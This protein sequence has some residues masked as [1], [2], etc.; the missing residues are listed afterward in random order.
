MPE[1]EEDN[2]STDVLITEQQPETDELPDGCWISDQFFSS[3][4]SPSFIFSATDQSFSPLWVLS[5]YNNNFNDG[6]DTPPENISLT[7]SGG[8]HVVLS[9][10]DEADQVTRKL[11]NN[12]MTRQLPMPILETNPPEYQ[13]ATCLIRERMTMALRYF[14]ESGYQK[15]VLAQVWAPVKKRDCYVLTTSGQPF[16]LD[17][18]CNGLHQ[19]RMASLM[20]IFSLGEPDGVLDLPARV[21]KHRLPE[22]T[23]NVQYYS[24]KE[25]QRL[26]H[27]LSYDVRGTLALPVFEPSG[28]ACVGVLELILTSQ[29]INYALEVDKVCRALEAVDLKTSDIL[30]SSNT[31]EEAICNQS[32]QQAIAEILEV[33]EVVCETY[34]FPLAQTWVPCR[35][36]SVLAYGGGFKKSNSSLDGS[37]MDQ[38]CMSITDVAFYVVDAHMWG[39]RDACAEHHLQKG[40]GVAGRAFATRSSCFC[41]NV[42]HF[43]KAEYPL[44]HYAR[45]FGL[46]GSFAICLRSTHT[47]DDDY[48]LEFFFPTH[49]VDCRDQQTLLGSLLISMKEHF[50]SFKRQLKQPINPKENEVKREIVRF[51]VL[52]QHFS[53]SLKDAAKNL[54]VCSAT[55]KRIC[56]QHGI[57]RWPSRKINKDADLNTFHAQELIPYKTIDGLKTARDEIDVALEIVCGSHNITL[58]QVWIAYEDQS[59]APFVSS[60][61]DTQTKP[62]LVR[63]LTGYSFCDMVPKETTSREE[64]AMKTIQDYKSRYVSNTLPDMLMAPTS[65][66]TENSTF[67]ICLKSIDTRDLGYAFEFI[68][69]KHSNY[70][71]FLEAILLTLKRFLPSF[72]FAFGAELGDEL[73]VID[74][75]SSTHAEISNFKIFQGKSLSS[76]LEPFDKRK[77]PIVDNIASS[78][79]KS[80]TSKISLPREV[81]EKQF[82]KTMIE[83]AKNL[84][85]SLSTF[86]RKFKDLG[87]PEWP[88]PNFVKRNAN[89]SSVIQINTNEEDNRAIQDPSTINMTKNTVTIKAEHAG[90]IIKFCLPISQATFQTIEKEIGIKFKLS[91][92]TYNLTYLDE[93]GDWIL[94]TAN[95]EMIDCIRISRK[96][97]RI[98]VRLRV[99]ASTQPISTPNG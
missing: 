24:D 95:E 6:D 3:G 1:T 96:S 31:L 37:C 73:E 4:P 14:I 67:I 55:I 7:S 27:A 26:N 2:R 82:G 92:G 11:W 5:D 21:F 35:H 34:N 65:E 10:T 32:R 64:L 40:E 16:V 79:G 44:V 63:K 39:F 54:G 56:R 36:R 48:V 8:A 74:V 93:D 66:D 58:A 75:E 20:Y 99:L 60:S 87:I 81:I 15:H 85:V 28:Q 68:W 38:V 46:V 62:L 72:K 9:D 86:K 78:E 17:P 80:K 43:G 13:D 61:E 77:K 22:W 89:N 84:N 52:Q 91:S 53:G 69:P 50:R 45:L 57:S 42:T 94:L 29:K 98:V 71:I 49:M 23:P 47:G 83:A 25:Y 97:D 41:E 70:V 30:D 33:I 88:G 18:N 12:D 51:E 76:I 90:Y 59:H 19:Y